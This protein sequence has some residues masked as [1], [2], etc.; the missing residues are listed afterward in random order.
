MPIWIG[1]RTRRSL[2]RAVVLADGWMPFG[3]SPEELRTALDS[4]DR[5][6]GFDV[7][8]WPDRALD[9]LGRPDGARRALDD[10][11]AM[12]TTIVNLTV[13]STSLAHHLEQLE[14]FVALGG[15]DHA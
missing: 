14:A 6:A 9:P 7:V 2:R 12:G 1:G 13:Q 10:L 5:P 11:A 15:L 3:L 8:L 4:V